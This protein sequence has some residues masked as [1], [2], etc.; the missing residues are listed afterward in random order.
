MLAGSAN[1]LT[2]GKP[3]LDDPAKPG[4]H[5][6]PHVDWRFW[7][8]VRFQSARRWMVSNDGSP[9]SSHWP[10]LREEFAPKWFTPRGVA[11]LAPELSAVRPAPCATGGSRHLCVR[12]CGPWRLLRCGGRRT[13]VRRAEDQPLTG[14]GRWIISTSR[15]C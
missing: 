4:A 5:I 7:P 10:S 14:P 9:A 3:F 2:R 13:T 12:L 1:A 8:A 6:G 11:A 15:P